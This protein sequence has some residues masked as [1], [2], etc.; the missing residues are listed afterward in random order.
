[1][2]WLRA[3][4]LS[5]VNSNKTG[6][7]VDDCA[8]KSNNWIDQ[9][10]MAERQIGYRKSSLV[11]STRLPVVKWRSRPVAKSSYYLYSMTR[12]V[13]FAPLWLFEWIQ[14]PSIL[15]QT[16]F[17][18]EI[19]ARLFSTSSICSSNCLKSLLASWKSLPLTSLLFPAKRYAI[20]TWPAAPNVNFRKI[21]VRKTIWDL[22]FAEHCCK[23]SC[24][25]ASPRIF[26]HLKNGAIVHF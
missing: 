12:L 5:T 3:S 14:W 8:R 10:Q 17:N 23:I 16:S 22:E 26:E 18:S 21:S 6:T 7:S 13:S 19:L 25:P 4:I 9:W 20:S 15:W 2:F 11:L 1:M 24:L